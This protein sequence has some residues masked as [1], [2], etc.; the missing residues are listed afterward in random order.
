MPV[1]LSFSTYAYSDAVQLLLELHEDIKG[2]IQ[3][4]LREIVHVENRMLHIYQQLQL[5]HILTSA[6]QSNGLH[7]QSTN[8]ADGE[9]ATLNL[10]VT[11]EKTNTSTPLSN[12]KLGK[13][14]CLSLIQNS[15]S[16]S[17]RKEHVFLTSSS[18]LKASIK[19]KLIDIAKNRAFEQPH[20]WTSPAKSL[21]QNPFPPLRSQRSKKFYSDLGFA[22]HRKLN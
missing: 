13:D 16:P 20:L 2:D 19:T 5:D 12:L 14:A 22:D 15:S 4:Q 1:T 8:E 3:C 21:A 18:P 7:S 10:E 17:P 11:M 6:K 9:I